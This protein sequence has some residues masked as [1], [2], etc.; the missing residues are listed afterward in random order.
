VLVVVI[1]R[2]RKGVGKRACMLILDKALMRRVMRMMTLILTV[3]L[4]QMNYTGM[5]RVDRRILVAEERGHDPDDPKS[6]P[7][8]SPRRAWD[9][10]VVFVFVVNSRVGRVR[11]LAQLGTFVLLLSRL[12]F[13]IPS[14][15]VRLCFY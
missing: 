8:R 10:V 11:A 12:N 15:P 5:G 14:Y 1:D 6:V 13:S 9:A 7:V 2:G 3:I 4:V